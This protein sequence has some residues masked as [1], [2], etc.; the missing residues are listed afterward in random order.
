MNLEIMGFSSINKTSI[1][2][3]KINDEKRKHHR[4]SMV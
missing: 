4:L 3:N 2:L 1:E